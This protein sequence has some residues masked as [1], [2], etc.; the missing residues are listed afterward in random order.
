M[1]HENFQW[2][3]KK[4]TNHINQTKKHIKL[5]NLGVCPHQ[6]LRVI[7]PTLTRCL[8]PQVHRFHALAS[9]TP[10]HQRTNHL[11]RRVFGRGFER[12]WGGQPSP[13]K[14]VSTLSSWWFQPFWKYESKWDIFPQGSGWT[15]KIYLSCHHLVIFFKDAV[16]KRRLGSCKLL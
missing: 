2:H 11:K 10:W 4:T 3:Q 14:K 7:F 15:L 5:P 8:P 1:Y 12:W 13:L 16:W 6:F 9:Q